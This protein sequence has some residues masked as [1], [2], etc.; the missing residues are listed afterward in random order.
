MVTAD[1]G[2]EFLD[3]GSWEHGSNLN[4]ELIRVPLVIKGPTLTPGVVHTQVQLVD[5][6]PTLLEFA[7]A[8]VPPSAGHSLIDV[9]RGASASS[10]ALSEIVGSQYALRHQ[11]LKLVD[12]DDGRT[13]LFDLGRDPLEHHDIASG[14]A[15]QV[16]RMRLVLNRMLQQALQ[17]GR[18]IRAERVPVD[19]VV[20]ERL[21]SLGYVPH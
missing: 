10:P 12:F 21:R 1:H 9:A 2:E 7:G 5:I 8:I 20:V 15:E 19:P 16:R 18:T 13:Q 11:G 4:D 17:T 3:H 6:F 14:N